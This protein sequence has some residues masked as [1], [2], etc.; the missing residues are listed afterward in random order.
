MSHPFETTNKWADAEQQAAIDAMRARM[1]LANGKR[2]MI[3]FPFGKQQPLDKYT[4]IRVLPFKKNPFV[5][6][7]SVILESP[8]PTAHYGFAKRD[9]PTVRGKL[10]SGAYEPVYI[11]ELK[12]D[13][14]AGIFAS[15]D[16]PVIRDKTGRIVRKELRDPDTKEILTERGVSQLVMWHG[17]QLVKIP[18]K[19]WMT[20]YEEPALMSAA[21][22]AMHQASFENF[23]FTPVQTVHEDYQGTDVATH[24]SGGGDYRSMRGKVQTE[25]TVE[26]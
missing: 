13:T 4:G 25:F 14:E 26:A 10:R 23:D 3:T 7:P 1:M 6:D 21:R 19:T 11:D 17:L 2:P 24:Q 22:L 8:D 16:V 12:E 20:E 9:D 5:D 15:E 18:H